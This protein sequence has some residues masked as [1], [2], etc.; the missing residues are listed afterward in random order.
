[1]RIVVVT[2]LILV[3][4]I[5]GTF[6]INQYINRSC[7]KLL[8]DIKILNKSINENEWNKA[9]D[10][11][12]NLKVQWKDTK[13]T[14]QLFLEHYEM[15]VIDIAI[16]RLNQ[17]VEIEERALALGEL[18]EFRLLISHIKDKEGLKLQNVL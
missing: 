7:E 10:H 4:F 16:A 17:Y 9:K 5:V 11:L 3:I 15:D 14:W 8:E 2:L 6:L 1:M 12:E 13:K 18:A